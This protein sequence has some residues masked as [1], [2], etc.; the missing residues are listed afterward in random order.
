MLTFINFRYTV[1]DDYDESQHKI[2]L[3]TPEKV[4]ITPEVF[5]ANTVSSNIV[6]IHDVAPVTILTITLYVNYYS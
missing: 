5:F 4:I 6:G 2:E 1:K 3:F